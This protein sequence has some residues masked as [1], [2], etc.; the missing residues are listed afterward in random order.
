MYGVAAEKWHLTWLED[1]RVR[2]TQTEN[3][4]IA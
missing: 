3:A 4:A 1:V 2:N